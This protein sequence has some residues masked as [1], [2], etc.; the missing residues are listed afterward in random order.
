M[1]NNNLTFE[2][3]NED[4]NNVGNEYWRK[5]LTVDSRGRVIDEPDNYI[6][7]LEHHPKYAGELLYNELSDTLK[8][9]GKDITNDIIYV[10]SY[11]M[12]RDINL[13]KLSHIK[14]AVEQICHTHKY[15]PVVDYLDSLKWDGEERIATIFNK[16]FGVEDNEVVRA[17]AKSWF[18]S[19]V[20]RAF[21][22]GH[23]LTNLLVIANDR[24]QEVY[25]FCRKIS[26]E[27]LSQYP[28]YNDSKNKKLFLYSS[29]VGSWL[30]Y[31]EYDGYS[32]RKP[33]DKIRADILYTNHDMLWGR[34]ND[35]K[36]AFIMDASDPDTLQQLSYRV[37]DRISLL[38]LDGNRHADDI[39]RTLTKDVVDQ[40]WAEAVHYYK[41]GIECDYRFNP[42]W[43]LYDDYVKYTDNIIAKAKNNYK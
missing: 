7:Y 31:V 43:E 26:K 10:M 41:S 2:A 42:D 38:M 16:C 14:W 11:D 20:D 35:R 4:T 36:C 13:C 40:L 3:P 37:S 17:M 5:Y 18:Y 21:N 19:A 22:P 12:E 23:E 6:K 9:G 32:I 25:R 15:N 27:F 24:W 39:C 1:K 30:S 8:F 29:I 34:T 33:I 28:V